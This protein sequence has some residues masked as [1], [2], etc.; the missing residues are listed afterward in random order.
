[1]AEAY[2]KHCQIYKMIR[3][4]GALLRVGEGSPLP[5]F[6][7]TNKFPDFGQKRP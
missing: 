4:T 7:N 6:E 3:L 1:M 5:F 2:S